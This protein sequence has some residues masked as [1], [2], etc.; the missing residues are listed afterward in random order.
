[1]REG[2][3]PTGPALPAM[4]PPRPP[5]EADGVTFDPS[6]ARRPPSSAPDSTTARGRRFEAAA[7][8][9][10][11]AAGWQVVGRNVRAGRLEIDL[12]IRRGRIVAFVEVKGRAGRGTGHPL[13]AITHRKRRDVGRVARQWIR[14]HGRPGECYRFD[15]VAVTPT[16]DGWW[17]EHVEDAW[18]E[19]R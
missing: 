9:Y 7:A 2:Q 19:V 17:V 14:N 15:A 4:P 13:E 8:R 5:G 6:P 3:I 11:E 12:I 16:R 10:L 1:M 18:R